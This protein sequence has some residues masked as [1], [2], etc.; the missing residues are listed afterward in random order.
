M[1]AALVTGTSIH[2]TGTVRVAGAA[3]AASDV[4]AAAPTGTAGLHD[5]DH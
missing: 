1:I 5:A 2:V 4:G 3:Q